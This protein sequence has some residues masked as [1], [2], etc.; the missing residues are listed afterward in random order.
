MELG[1]CNWSSLYKFT[2]YDLLTEGCKVVK[3]HFN[4]FK[5]LKIYLGK[6][7][8]KIYNIKD[9]DTSK[10][11]LVEISKLEVYTNLFLDKQ[12]NTI[13]IVCHSTHRPKSNYWNTELTQ[14]DLKNEEDQFNNLAN[15]LRTFNKTFILQNWES[16]NYKDNT[17]VSTRNMIKW[18]KH[19]QAGIDLFRKNSNNGTYDNVFH[20]IEI[21]RI[22]QKDSVI[23]KVIPHVR[24]DLVS[25]SC[26]DTQQNPENFEKAIKLILGS[27][28][29]NR[30][31]SKGVP[32]C[33]DR[34]PVPLYIGEFGLS[35]KNKKSFQIMNTLYNI[36]TISRKYNLPYANFWNLYNNE[37][38][39]EFG[40]IDNSN[41][42]TP[43]GEFFINL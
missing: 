35:H 5:T 14:D 18:I 8:S 27:I 7:S 23:H 34:L 33:L 4:K 29:R 38:G 19:R 6:R 16:D 3:E 30:N 41:K 11:T 31:Y 15:Y 42:I 2:N 20:A 26:Y 9:V 28:N 32:K 12:F 24:I 39:E 1:I 25:Y 10:L 13:I 43:S 40:L 21:N 36:I 17:D 22:Y 37:D